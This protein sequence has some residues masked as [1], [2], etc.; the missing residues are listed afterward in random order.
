MAEVERPRGPGYWASNDVILSADG[1]EEYVVALGAKIQD[2][3]RTELAKIFKD[4][5]GVSVSVYV[6]PDG[7]V[8]YFYG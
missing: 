3:V 4:F 5:P 6:H 7:G 8:E 1:I 2:S